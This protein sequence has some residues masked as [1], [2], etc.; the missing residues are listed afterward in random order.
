MEGLI[1]KY[2]NDDEGLEALIMFGDDE[3]KWRVVFRDSDADATIFV[4]FYKDY[5]KAEREAAE[6]FLGDYKEAA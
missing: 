4:R 3:H 6:F 5:L 2:Y 1:S